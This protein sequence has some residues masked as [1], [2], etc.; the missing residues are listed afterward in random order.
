[1]NII[2]DLNKYEML[3]FAGWILW[4]LE[5]WTFGWNDE[6]CCLLEKI[7][8][9]ISLLMIIYGLIGSIA[10]SV[11]EKAAE[12]MKLIIDVRLEKIFKDIF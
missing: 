5:S 4:F 3:M 12:E 2:K 9:I 1:M 11:M 6:P 10:F 7:L 8:D